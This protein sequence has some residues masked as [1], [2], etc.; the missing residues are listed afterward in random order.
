MSRTVAEHLIDLMLEAGIRNVYGVVGDSANPVADA[1]RRTDGK[2]SFIHVRNEEAGAFAA[3]ADA[4]V[5]GRPT[6]VL[7][8]SGPGS[9]H[10]LNGLYDCD[11]NGAPVFAIVTHIPSTEIGTRYFQELYPGTS[12]QV[13]FEC[14]FLG[15]FVQLIADALARFA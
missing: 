9:L 6:A 8:S 2:L 5:S 1:I 15:G 7:G 13:I 11:R 14:M 4:M 12:G 3:G 10:L